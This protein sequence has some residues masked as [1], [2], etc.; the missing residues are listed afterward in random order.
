MNQSRKMSAVEA[1]A[2]TVAGFAINVTLQTL[3]FPLFGVDLP[4][5]SNLLI[6][7]IF[8]GSSLA[9]GYVLRRVFE[10]FRRVA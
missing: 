8:T 4:L 10:T 7:A 6:G 3:V 1:V 2:S 9:R 5:S